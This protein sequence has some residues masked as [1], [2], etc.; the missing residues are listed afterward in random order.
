MS[1]PYLRERRDELLRDY[2]D[3]LLRDVAPFWLRFGLDREHGGMLTALGRR[4]E[5]ID[6]D[7]SVWFQGRA[8][9]TYATLFRRVER[10]PEWLDAALSC[11]RFLRDHCAGPS[12][13][14]L[15]TVTREGKPLRMRRYVFSE[16]FAAIAYAAV[17]AATGEAEWRERALGA[18]ATFLRYQHEPGH[19]APK[20]EPT[21]RPSVGLSPW[22]IQLV[23][24]QDLREC[25]GDVEVLGRTLTQWAKAACDAIVRLF[26]KPDLRAVMEQVAPDGS[27]IDHFDGRLLNPGHA[28]EAAWF[29]L[30]EARRSGDAALATTSLQ[31]LD[32]MWERGWDREHGGLLYFTDLHGK[33][34]QEYWAHMKFWWPHNEAM[35][36]TL[37]AHAHTGDPRYAEMHRA[38]HD[39]SRARFPDR[40]H[41]EWFGYLDRQ[42]RPTTE[43][44]G[45]MWKG[46][47][48]LPR[49]QL[50]CWEILE[51]RFDA[52]SA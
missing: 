52:T 45:N 5:V 1:T 6:T 41:G 36:A 18:F 44:K 14:L 32:W 28:I 8:G 37:L 2:R 49:Q 27:V 34:V 33:P 31:M 35:I 11:V 7:K 25:L 38:V 23:T 20:V 43:L 40:E 30:R 13:K 24:A 16:S 10:R 51:G 17:H 3:A 50:V 21:T 26:V 12:G 9:W 19:I 39:W 42:G 22:M 47:F 48:H 4:G 15:F 46:P 29:L